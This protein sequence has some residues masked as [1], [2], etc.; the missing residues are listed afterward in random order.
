MLHSCAPN[1][2]I[3]A[4]SH[5]VCSRDLSSLEDRGR[6]HDSGLPDGGVGRGQ[7]KL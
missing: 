5:Q 2:L 6:G 7:A 4:V 1:H 3:C